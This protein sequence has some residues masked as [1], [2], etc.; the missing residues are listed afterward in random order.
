MIVIHQQTV[1]VVHDALRI[2]AV[3]MVFKSWLR[4]NIILVAKKKETADL[5]IYLL[6]SSERKKNIMFVKN[7]HA[8]LCIFFAVFV[9]IYTYIYISKNSV[10]K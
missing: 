8:Y 5:T 2:Y 4:A 1:E 9:F 3:V 6:D 10:V 7:V